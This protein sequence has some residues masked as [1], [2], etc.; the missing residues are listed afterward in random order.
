VLEGVANITAVKQ[1]DEWL[2]PECLAHYD[3][4]IATRN[5]TQQ[6]EE[7]YSSIRRRTHWRVAFEQLLFSHQDEVAASRGQKCYER[8]SVPT[9][10]I[11]GGDDTVD[12]TTGFDIVGGVRT[13]APK[14]SNPGRAVIIENTGH[15]IDHER[16]KWLA[17]EILRF[18]ETIPL[19]EVVAVSRDEGRISRLHLARPDFELAVPSSIETSEV[20]R[21]ARWPGGFTNY[22]VRSP[23]GGRTRV[24]ARR[25]L[26]TEPDDTTEN[27]LRSLPETT[28]AQ[29]EGQAARSAYGP[30]EGFQVTHIRLMTTGDQPWETWV[31]HLCNDELRRQIPTSEAERRIQHGGARYFIQVGTETTDLRVVEYLY[32]QP[33]ETTEDNLSSLPELEA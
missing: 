20:I 4:G 3:A 14:M 29:L 31:S 8:S 9:L 21:R 19:R 17:R 32:T 10:L 13:I 24:W 6:L 18:L 2:R 33:N 12:R 5:F 25:I 15:S 28:L 23:D 7:R 30:E 26:T 16:P 22:W 11:A 1:S 27:N